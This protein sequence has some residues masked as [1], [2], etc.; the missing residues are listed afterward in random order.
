LKG[1][2]IVS[3]NAKHIAVT[4]TGVG[5]D[6]N[7]KQVK[8]VDIE[9]GTTARDILKSMNLDGYVMSSRRHASFH[10]DDNI[11]PMVESGE[12]LNASPRVDAGF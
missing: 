3:A 12:D 1:G 11:Y 8:Q 7:A 5:G 10:E 2:E 6:P 4:V 9:P